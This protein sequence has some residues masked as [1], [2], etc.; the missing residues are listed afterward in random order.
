MEGFADAVRT[1]H[2]AAV[3]DSRRLV[4]VAAEAQTHNS[5]S[6]LRHLRQAVA[7]GLAERTRDLN[8]LQGVLARLAG[9]PLTISAWEAGVLP[10]LITD[11][12]VDNAR[13]QALF[14][15][16]ATAVAGS[17]E[18]APATRGFDAELGPAGEV[19][20]LAP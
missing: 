10:H 6:P 17:P 7:D 9:T 3:L 15:G 14:A 19:R 2:T 1:A 5:D 20:I 18:A 11:R 8:R 13:A 16:L 12:A 4:L